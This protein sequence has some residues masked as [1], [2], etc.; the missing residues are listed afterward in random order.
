MPLNEIC[1]IS[2][3][4]LRMSSLCRMVSKMT[5]TPPRH[6]NVCN[7]HCRLTFFVWKL[8]CK[9]A[10][11]SHYCCTI[12]IQ[13]KKI[14]W[15]SSIH[16]PR[17]R[18]LFFNMGCS[19]LVLARLGVWPVPLPKFDGEGWH[20]G[21]PANLTTPKR[22]HVLYMIYDISKIHMFELQCSTWNFEPELGRS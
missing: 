14:L 2:R 1:Y 7:F 16:C 11:I 8:L 17:T 18:H 19:M 3:L 15:L 22:R 4:D 5:R 20:E 13:G 10:A 12:H 21:G 9:S 6:W